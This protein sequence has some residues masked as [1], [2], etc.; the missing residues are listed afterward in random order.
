MLRWNKP[1]PFPH[2]VDFEDI[3]REIIGPSIVELRVPGGSATVSSVT[4]KIEDQA[5]VLAERRPKVIRH[6]MR[7]DIGS[8]I[9]SSRDIDFID[10]S[11]QK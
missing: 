1:A 5:I 3:D 4:G 11:F 2:V 10:T 7:N 6:I 8:R 9:P